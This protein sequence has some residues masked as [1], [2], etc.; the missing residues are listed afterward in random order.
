MVVCQYGNVDTHIGHRVGHFDRRAEARIAAVTLRCRQGGFEIDHGYV[1]IAEDMR[2][3][4][5]RA[6]VVVAAV[7][8]T[9]RRDLRHVLHQ[10]AAEYEPHRIAPCRRFRQ[11]RRM[12]LRLADMQSE[13][14][15]QRHCEQ[16]VG[17]TF[18][19]SNKDSR[20]EHIMQ[21][22][23]IACNNGRICDR[24]PAV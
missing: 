14:Q 13:I 20:N 19:P 3:M 22:Y 23:R 1:G 11:Y 7:G 12:R 5:E 21:I 18:H 4:L 9:C 24:Y 6:A 8:C 17:Q 15:A 10:I 2:H 16:Y